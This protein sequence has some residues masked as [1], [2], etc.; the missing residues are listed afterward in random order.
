[1]L[2][3]HFFFAFLFV[4]GGGCVKEGG[5][6]FDVYMLGSILLSRYF[7]SQCILVRLF[8]NVLLLHLLSAKI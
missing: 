6:G 8:F 1:M 7:K 4:C 2:L 3:S 5:G